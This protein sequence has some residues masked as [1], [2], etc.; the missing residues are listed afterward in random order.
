METS[1]IGIPLKQLAHNY[2]PRTLLTEKLLKLNNFGLC[3]HL[4]LDGF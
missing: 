1:Q 3:L 4:V 2:Y